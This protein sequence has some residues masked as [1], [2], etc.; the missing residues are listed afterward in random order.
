MNR[1]NLAA[2]RSDIADVAGVCSTDTRI[3]GWVNEAQ[4]RL[5]TKGRWVGA[6]V[7]YRFCVAESCLT[8]PRQVETVEAWALCDTPMT[9]RD[10]WYE[11][12]DNGPGQQRSDLGA[13]L[14]LIDRGTA[15]T[16]RDPSGTSSLINVV[17]AVAE[18]ASARILLQGYDENANWVR[19]QDAGVWIDGEYVAITAAGTRS[20][21]KFTNLTGVS[22]P[23]TNGPVNLFEWPSTLGANLQQ[24]AYYEHDETTPIYRRYLL[25]NIANVSACSTATS[26][27]A[28][29][30]VTALVKL[31][32]LPVFV[33]NDWLILGNR[34]AL[35]L[36]VQA[37]FKERRNL[38][39]EAAV[40]EAKA[41]R[42]L[43]SELSSYEGDGVVPVLRVAGADVWGGAIENAISARFSNV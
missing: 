26:S 6:V 3:P 16:Y 34:A 19:T 29:K 17:A 35:K 28:D 12:I 8:L 32:H 4:E 20:T 23:L 38:F 14:N 43:E 37:I 10:R 30:T 2:I 18:S 25:P 42:E 31:R 11:F 40:Y 21:R 39:D 36:M 9:V 7:R 1:L 5:M 15:C 33:D 41:L 24:L 13:S 22:K 27:C